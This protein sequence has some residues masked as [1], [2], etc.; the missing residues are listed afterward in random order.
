LSHGNAAFS[1]VPNT[2]VY[3]GE[4]SLV[5]ILPGRYRRFEVRLL[6]FVLLAYG[7]ASLYF[8]RLCH[9]GNPQRKISS[10]IGR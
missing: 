10:S 3:R 8:R 2:L 9:I 4:R 7:N 6:D 1:C 5:L